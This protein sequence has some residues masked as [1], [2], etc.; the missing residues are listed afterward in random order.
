MKC[1]S[2]N[3]WILQKYYVNPQHLVFKTK[4]PPQ[5]FP[6]FEKILRLPLWGKSFSGDQWSPLRRG[7]NFCC[8]RRG[9]HCPPAILHFTFF[10]FASA[11]TPHPSC[12]SA[13]PPSPEEKAFGVPAEHKNSP[14]ENPG[15]CRC[16][17][18]D[19]VQIFLRGLSYFSVSS[20]HISVISR[21]S[22]QFL[23]PTFS[24]VT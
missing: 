24:V 4:S 13:M 7:K 20:I 18:S 21:T 17:I 5:K 2:K 19:R 8:V 10:K 15:G 11:C 14:P 22:P 12:P 23:S 6:E 1:F 9:G 16:S 3:L